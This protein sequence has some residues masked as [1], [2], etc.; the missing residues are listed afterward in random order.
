MLVR[1]KGIGGGG[2]RRTK[3]VRYWKL[4]I[5]SSSVSDNEV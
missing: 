2:G 4:L 5:S 3:G 1:E